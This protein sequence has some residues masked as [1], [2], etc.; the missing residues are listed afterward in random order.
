MIMP[1]KSNRAQSIKQ[2]SP[3]RTFI[4]RHKVWSAIVVTVLIMVAAV[5]TLL[6]VSKISEEIQR[7]HF[8]QIKEDLLTLQQRLNAEDGGGWEY[9]EEC[10][11]SGGGFQ[12][13]ITVCELGIKRTYKNLP[14]VN[15]DKIVKDTNAILTTTTSSLFIPSANKY[16][17]RAPRL[18]KITFDTANEGSDSSGDKLSSTRWGNSLR[19]GYAYI[20]TAPKTF[21]INSSVLD[22]EIG[23]SKHT[24]RTYF[25]RTD[26]SPQFSDY[27]AE[28]PL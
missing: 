1:K 12:T 27:K 15:I 19:C 9:N 10:R 28:Y 26:V 23:C 13:T 2:S 7:Q 11:R 18:D 17:E 20:L 14:Q 5:F 8:Q 4:G 22:I 3:L 21:P 24:Q 6:I 25:N 16:A